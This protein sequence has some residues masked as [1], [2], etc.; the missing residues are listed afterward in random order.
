M[1]DDDNRLCALLNDLNENERDALYNLM[2]DKRGTYT[3]QY[4]DNRVSHLNQR[5]RPRGIEQTSTTG[6]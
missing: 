5:W 6:G 4:V 3:V 1:S 2:L